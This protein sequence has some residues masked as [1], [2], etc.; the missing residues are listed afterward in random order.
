MQR[1]LASSSDTPK[2]CQ[3]TQACLVNLRCIS[4]AAA[5]D[6][7]VL[8]QDD[9]FLT[10]MSNEWRIRHQVEKVAAALGDSGHFAVVSDTP[11]SV[12]SETLSDG[13]NRVV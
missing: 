4:T 5:A 8:K 9:E 2:S 7:S 13:F 6:V 10:G 3:T 11:K 1:R 12:E